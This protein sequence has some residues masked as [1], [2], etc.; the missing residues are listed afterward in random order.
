LLVVCLLIVYV[1]LGIGYIKQGAQQADIDAQISG[2]SRALSLVPQPPKDLKQR[3]EAAEQAY[4]S[5]KQVVFPRDLNTTDVIAAVLKTADSYNVSVTPLSTSPWVEKKVETRVFLVFRISLKVEGAYDAVVAFIGQ[6]EE[7]EFQS[8]VVESAELTGNGD[9][10]SAIYSGTVD[11][12]V[13]TLISE[14][15]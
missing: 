13:Y 3:L 12:A 14:D 1:Y 5:A 9:G 8:M 2:S 6:L 4:A 10:A 15:T 11:L 7:K